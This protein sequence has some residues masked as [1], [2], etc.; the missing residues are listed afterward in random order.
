MVANIFANIC[1]VS[2]KAKG[3]L[4]EHPSEDFSG[5]PTSF[6]PYIDHFISP[7]G[8]I[9]NNCSVEKNSFFFFNLQLIFQWHRTVEE[10]NGTGKRIFSSF[11]NHKC[12]LHTI[13]VR[14][15][16]ALALRTTIQKII[17]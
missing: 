3:D 2:S 13:N 11:I 10:T 4:I 9:I 16:N 1:M 14:P 17:Y 15:L 12:I 7:P 6:K 8:C 5:T